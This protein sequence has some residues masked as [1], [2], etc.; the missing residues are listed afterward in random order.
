MAS[1]VAVVDTFLM[2]LLKADP[3][4]NTLVAGRVYSQ[5]ATLYTAL[6]VIV[7]RYQPGGNASSDWTGVR[8]E[9]QLLYEVCAVGP[10]L[11]L[12]GLKPI[13]DRID[14]L[15]EPLQ[16]DGAAYRLNAELVQS[17]ERPDVLAGTTRYAHLGGVY[18]LRYRP[19]L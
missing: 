10:G 15:L 5:M 9:S 3:V 19:K 6:P 8:Y 4:L 12:D 13:A 2:A 11:D 14:A 18:R 16:Y 1:D 7:S 17:V